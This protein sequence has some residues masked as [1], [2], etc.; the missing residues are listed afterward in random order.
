VAGVGGESAEC[1]EKWRL[2]LVDGSWFVEYSTTQI[3]KDKGRERG[4]GR[5]DAD[6]T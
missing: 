1:R 2:A 3:V 5:I 6:H 4:K